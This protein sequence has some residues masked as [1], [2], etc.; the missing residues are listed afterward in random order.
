MDLDFWEE[1]GAR[2]PRPDLFLANLA[3]FLP[4]FLFLETLEFLANR[5]FFDA[6]PGCLFLANFALRFSCPG[7]FLA[8]WEEFRACFSPLAPLPFFLAA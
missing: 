4:V 3:D 8:P 5:V 7:C 6:L 2:F 1:A